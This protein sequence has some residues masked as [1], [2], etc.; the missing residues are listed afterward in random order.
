M[1]ILFIWPNY[2]CPIGMSIGVAYLSSVLQQEGFETKILHI[3]EEL[4]YP[5]NKEMIV[6]DIRKI[7]PDIVC[8]STGENHYADM[9]DLSKSIKEKLGKTIIIGGIHATLNAENIFTLDSPFDYLMRGEGEWAIKELMIG[10]RDNKDTSNIQN[11][12]MKKDGKIIKNKMRRFMDNFSLPYMD[13]DN[14]D[15]E[16]I[17]KLRRGWV[18][19]SM[20]RGCPYRCTFCH[21]LAEVKILKDDFDCPTTSNKEL[22]Y[23]RLRNIDN[24]INELKHIKDKYDFVKAFSFID[25]TF[26][27]DKEYMKKFF[28]RYKNE[29]GL[30]FVCLTTINDVDDELLEL[31]KKANCDLIRFGVESTTERICK[32]I[33]KRKFS[34]KKLREVFKKCKEIGLRTFSYNIVAHPTETKEEIINT[35][36]LNSELQ[37][38]GLRISLG[39]PYK[40][41]EY[42]EIAKKMGQLDETIEYHNYST[43]TRFKFS[44]EQKLWIDKFKSFFWWWL[45]VNQNEYL[46][47]LYN[48]LIM[49]L[50]SI[51]MKD[52][53]D[54]KELI[55]DH[56]IKI[57][58]EI[59]K[60]LQEKSIPHYN[61]PYGDRPDIA[62]HQNNYVLKKELLD[63]H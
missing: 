49:E 31:M 43:G 28:I 54:N 45:N 55:L 34:E 4:G 20:N 11:V 32:N 57:D 33:I 15:F 46:Y 38:S 30:P 7:N 56:Y 12:W 58:R 63:E 50:E 13:L 8:I 59:S 60:Y 1:K 52:W 40:G 18:N 22:G 14:W 29:I 6:E 10:L 35:M 36:Q 9:Y 44:S 37:P 17:T 3:N 51:D 23:L 53:Y 48:P 39:Y 26:T 61:A 25:D 2:D 19:I 27:Y 16:R 41:T 5:Y 24:M 47:S 42:Y 62:I 21:N